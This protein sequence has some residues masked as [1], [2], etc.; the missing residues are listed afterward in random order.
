MSVLL[1]KEHGC[2]SQTAFTVSDVPTES[3]MSSQR[4]ERSLKDDCSSRESQDYVGRTERMC[5]D[6]MLSCRYVGECE[7]DVEKHSSP[8]GPELGL[9][10]RYRGPNRGGKMVS[11][12]P[13]SG[14][15]LAPFACASRCSV[16]LA[17]AFLFTG[18]SA[19]YVRSQWAEV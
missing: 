1:L 10:S 12:G 7:S 8:R 17:S 15:E 19:A 16:R 3:D 5:M 14:I 11:P 13:T 2:P 4:E 18:A 6:T 9:S